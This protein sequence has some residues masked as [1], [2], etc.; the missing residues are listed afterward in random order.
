MKRSA[1]RI[2]VPARDGGTGDHLRP[3]APCAGPLAVWHKLTARTG[4]ENR[5]FIP[6]PRADSA[7]A[8]GMVR[9]QCLPHRRSRASLRQHFRRALGTGRADGMLILF[10]CLRAHIQIQTDVQTEPCAQKPVRVK[11]GVV[12][13]GAHVSRE[14]KRRQRRTSGF[15]PDGF[16]FYE[17]GCGKDPHTGT[18]AV[19][20]SAK[21][22]H[23]RPE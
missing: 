3:K 14:T 13:K 22:L 20:A 21:I 12:A 9:R 6:R 16:G 5:Q 2:N 4:I 8:A 23:G 18:W 15:D 11:H 10:P 1:F 19:K 7:R 17:A